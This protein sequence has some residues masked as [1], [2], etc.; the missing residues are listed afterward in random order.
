MKKASQICQSKLPDNTALKQQQL[1]AYRLQLSA[2]G[3]LSGFFATG[4]F[5]LGVGIILIL[6]A[7]SIKEIEIKYTKICANCA[8]LREDAIN[9]DKECTC[10]I[11]FYLSETMQVSEIQELTILS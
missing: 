8:E 6:S 7:K 9:F 3:V 10:S 4:A 5:C 2:T 11:P 1:P